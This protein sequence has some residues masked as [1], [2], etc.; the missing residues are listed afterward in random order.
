MGHA[1]G[2]QVAQRCKGFGAAAGGA[3]DGVVGVQGAFDV[4]AHPVEQR[5]QRVQALGVHAAGVQRSLKAQGAHLLQRGGQGGLQRG[6][7]AREDDAVEQA[8]AAVQKGQH[9]GPGHG[10][11]GGGAQQL[12]VV[13]VAAAPGAALAIKHG[14]QAAGEVDAGERRDA[15]DAQQR[16]IGVC[17][18]CSHHGHRHGPVRGVALQVNG[19]WGFRQRTGARGARPACRC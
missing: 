15:A 5:Q 19:H 16:S 10:G 8:L 4:Q 17:G 14:G 12:G 13:A 9:L 2:E 6:F 11:G 3:R 18:G 1:A 7:A